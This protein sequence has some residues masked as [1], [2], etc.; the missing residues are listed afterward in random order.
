MPLPT[1]KRNPFPPSFRRD[2]T[3]TLPLHMPPPL[4]ESYV[5]LLCPLP[6]DSK[7]LPVSKENVSPTSSKGDASPYLLEEKPPFPHL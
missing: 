1:S 7:P 2:T 6:C 4:R 3:L 5:K